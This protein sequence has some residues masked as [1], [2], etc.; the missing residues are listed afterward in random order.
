MNLRKHAT[1]VAVEAASGIAVLQI[2]RTTASEAP[3]RLD[4]GAPV[5]C[6]CA[7]KRRTTRP[8]PN[9]SQQT[10]TSQQAIQEF[11]DEK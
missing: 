2:A 10:E 6:M 11:S 7:S 5:V 3:L 9:E 1:A 8:F 4:P